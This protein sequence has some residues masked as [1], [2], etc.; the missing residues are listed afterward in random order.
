MGDTMT[1][2]DSVGNIRMS[3]DRVQWCK[4]LTNQ[5]YYQLLNKNAVNQ[6]VRVCTEF[7]WL[8]IATSVGCCENG[9]ELSRGIS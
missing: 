5:S 8:R 1:G 7:N 3:Q 9:N 4:H 2:N 6:Y